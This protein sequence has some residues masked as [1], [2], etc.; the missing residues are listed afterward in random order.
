M[1]MLAVLS[2]ILVIAGHGGDC[3][4]PFVKQGVAANQEECLAGGCIAWGQFHTTV[5][6]FLTEH[7]DDSR[8]E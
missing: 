3:T 1:T 2:I 4:D 7:T 8:S 6:T 5:G